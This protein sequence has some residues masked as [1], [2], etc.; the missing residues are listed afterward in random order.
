MGKGDKKTRRGKII[1]GS[2]GVRRPKNKKSKIH[3]PHKEVVVV[4]KTEV[5][6]IPKEKIPLA[7][8]IASVKSTDKKAPTKETKVKKTVSAKKIE[9]AEATKSIEEKKPVSRK[10][11]STKA[12][13]P[14]R[15]KKQK[16]T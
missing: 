5:E 6:D 4:E 7:K 1:K 3:S 16:E 11:A 2:F 12:E 9:S 15:P 13:A 8:K 14:A 10:K